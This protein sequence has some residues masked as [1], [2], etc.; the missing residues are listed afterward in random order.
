MKKIFFLLLSTLSLSAA[1]E[2]TVVRRAAFD[3][4]SGQIKMQVSDVDVTTNQIVDVLLIDFAVVPL[5]EDVMK[6]LDGRLSLAMQDQA[7]QA[8]SELMQKAAPFHPQAYRAV[9]TES[10]RPAQ[11]S[12][13]FLERIQNE[14][15]LSVRVISQEEEGIL[16]F[17]SAVS[18]AKVDPDKAVSWDFGG[19]SFQITTKLEDRYIVYQGKLGSVPMKNA[20]LKIQ[21]NKTESPNPISQFEADEALRMIAKSLEEMPEA[22][23]QKLQEPDVAVLSVGINPLWGLKDSTPFDRERLA[24]ELK[25]RLGL[26]DEA[27]MI[28]DGVQKQY[29]SRRVTNVLLVYG[30]M[31]ALKMGQ[32]HYV[33]TQGANAIGT[34]LS[35]TYWD[36]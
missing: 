22:L 6:S 13:E 7:V 18:T 2:Q 12:D 28:K 29:A 1:T 5:R 19:G 14:T 4:G 33:G 26:D 15:G 35:P 36:E 20:V 30:V 23:R 10:L 21:G 34:L 16:G 31:E 9:A 3:I 24:Q 25:A 17:I 8:I 11:N 32:V 27:I